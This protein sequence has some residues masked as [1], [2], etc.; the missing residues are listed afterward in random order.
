MKIIYLRTTLIFL[1]FL[2]L[3]ALS[4][5]LPPKEELCPNNDCRGPITIKL[6]KED[7]SIFEQKHEYLYPIIQSM[8]IT[9]FAGENIKIAGTFENNKLSNIHALKESDQEPPLFTFSFWQEDKDMMI[10]KVVN[11]S[12]HD[13]KYHLAMMPLKE[14]NFFKTSSCPVAASISAIESW[15]YPIYQLLI[16]EI[17]IIEIKDQVTCEY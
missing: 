8:G 17:F 10:L 14:E 15:P 6:I 4:N 11:N 1:L 2:P 12:K 3:T 9:I 13:I 16:P 7:G 5:D